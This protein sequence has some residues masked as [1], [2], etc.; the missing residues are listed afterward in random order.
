M[1]LRLQ[2][3]NVPIQSNGNSLLLT[4]DI[5]AV[6]LFQ[7]ENPSFSSGTWY[8]HTGNSNSFQLPSRSLTS[9][10]VKNSTSSNRDFSFKMWTKV[11]FMC[12][13]FF[14]RYSYVYELPSWANKKILEVNKYCSDSAFGSEIYIHEQVWFQFYWFLISNSFRSWQTHMGYGPLIPRKPTF[15]AYHCMQLALSFG[16]LG[17]YCIVYL[18]CFIC[19]S[20]LAF[21]TSIASSWRRF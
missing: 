6:L 3:C 9:V 1:H 15:S 16:T 20:C 13:L 5:H 21:S 10:A 18:L 11:V 4:P 7:C 2:Y 17:R 14:T 8:P 19:H 12:L